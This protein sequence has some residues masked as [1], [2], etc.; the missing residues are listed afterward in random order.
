MIA[1]ALFAALG[2]PPV[3]VGVHGR[4]EAEVRLIHEA[5]EA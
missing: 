2:W 3:A 1:V 5:R 4:R